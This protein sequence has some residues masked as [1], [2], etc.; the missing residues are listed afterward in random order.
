MSL[1]MT[2]QERETFLAGLHVAIISIPEEGR[3]PLTVP[4]WPNMV[5]LEGGRLEEILTAMNRK[6]PARA[7]LVYQNHHFGLNSRKRVKGDWFHAGNSPLS[8]YPEMLDEVCKY[9]YLPKDLRSA[10]K[11]L[12][13]ARVKDGTVRV[14]LP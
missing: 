1:A 3:G 8:L 14:P 5:T 2:K 7:A 6:H 4:T 12:L 9:A 10:Y 13:A 11:E